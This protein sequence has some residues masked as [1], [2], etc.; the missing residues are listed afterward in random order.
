MPLTQAK[1]YLLPLHR[2]VYSGTVYEF[3]LGGFQFLP[4]AEL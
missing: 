4:E 3:K 2:S 1:T